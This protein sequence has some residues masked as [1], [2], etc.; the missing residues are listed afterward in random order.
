MPDQSNR[1][2]ALTAF[3]SA[4]QSAFTL[5]DLQDTA[6]AFMREQLDVDDVHIADSTI[7][8]E[9]SADV[10]LVPIQQT[11]YS[12]RLS[13][14]NPLDEE[15]TAVVKIAASLITDAPFFEK[16]T[17]TLQQQLEELN[18]LYEANISMTAKI[19][20]DD[21]LQTV[22]AEM[23]QALK[24]DSCTIFVWDVHRHK[25]KPAAHHNGLTASDTE[26][27]LMGLNKVA[28][29]AEHPALQQIME[30]PEIRSL[31]R[32]ESASE[33]DRQLLEAANLQTVLLAPL[34]RQ[35]KFL[36]LLGLGQ[37]TAAR[38]FTDH[39]LRLTKNLAN[40]AAVAIEH[41]NLFRQAQ[42]RIQELSTFQDIVLQLN[43]P[44]KLSEVLATIT[45][46]ALKLVDASNMHIYLYN[47]ETDAFTFGSALWQ[48]G[49]RTPAVPAPRKEGLTMAVVHKREPIVI[50]DAGSHPLFQSEKSRS[51]GI[52]SIAGFPL[53][54]GNQ[55]IGAFTATFLHPHAFSE[56]EQLV[57]SLLADQAAVAVR[58]AGLFA[59]S[60][61]RLRD[62]AALVDMAKQVTG[63][64]KLRSVLQTTVQ[65]IKGL[66]SARASTITML[67]ESA[68]ELVVV[69]AAGADPEAVDKARMKLGEGVS[70]Q[71]VRAAELVYIRDAHSEPDFLFFDEVVRS[72][73]V[74]PL[75]I[76]DRAIGTMTVDNAQPNAFSESDIQLMMI[77]AAQVSVAIA[78]ARLFEELEERA[79]ELA[80]AYEELKESDRLKDEL[81]QNV[82]HELRT[83]LT[84][85]KGYVDLLMEG[86][87]GLVTPHQ[88][89]ALLIVAEK[90][91][92]ITRLIEDI[93]TL[94][95]ID[96]GNLQLE[97]V[98]LAEMI[99]TAVASHTLVADKKG[100]RIVSQIPDG[101][102]D[103]AFIDKQRI[104]QVLDNIIGNAL[105]F[106][107]DGGIITVALF[108]E[109]DVIGIAVS[110]QGVGVPED[111]RERIF[112][113]F[114]QV[115]GSA[116]RR[117]GGTGVG[118]AIVK[119]I[120]DAHQGRIWVESAVKEGSTFFITLPKAAKQVA[121]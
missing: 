43:T 56:D 96:A 87:M 67:S 3:Q 42:R 84:F 95:R 52:C 115:D 69:A 119:R 104:N 80:A 26:P 111:K 64:L 31:R 44:L 61:R 46:S 93:I 90:T 19:D 79:A 105:K 25:L 30:T 23:A 28:E 113:R 47:P 11:G 103:L 32:D 73:L 92:E 82:S 50:N 81:V 88:Q 110:D 53:R 14:D 39:E 36:G 109:E 60:Q 71:V 77:A 108:E 86:E 27:Q 120:V 100:M 97:K 98:S 76:R 6:V 55:V 45:K 2:R 20:R 118:L 74:V 112:E 51:W 4:V 99:K 37:K 18:T 57:L 107:P 85:V 94:Q 63:N 54:H 116:R 70:G 5:Q 22:V 16:T 121:A 21:V 48:D 7:P 102:A 41:A 117:F 68:T 58:N 106:S 89:E 12:L 114:Y 33:I 34:M 83:P 10:M 17:T 40:Q 9:G 91:D 62:M 13:R 15:E 66:L 75:I 59:G 1:F 35:D 72:L 78:N 8:D 29:L 24:L 65:T 101:I 49:R 38:T